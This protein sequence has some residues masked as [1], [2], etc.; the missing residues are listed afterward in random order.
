LFQQFGKGDEIASA[1]HGYADVLIQLKKPALA[2]AIEMD[3]QSAGQIKAVPSSG[4]SW[5]PK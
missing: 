4:T 3:F 5:Q 2:S 1:E